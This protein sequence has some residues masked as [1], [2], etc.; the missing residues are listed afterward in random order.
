MECLKGSCGY[1]QGAKEMGGRQ[2]LQM[3]VGSKQGVQTVNVKLTR[4]TQP[5]HEMI[6]CDQPSSSVM[7]SGQMTSTVRMKP[8]IAGLIFQM[9][10]IL[11]FMGGLLMLQ[12]WQLIQ[13]F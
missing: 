4:D 9:K 3:S 7:G 10:Q 13:F 8:R 1:G 12:S 5:G 6:L 11:V 2:Q